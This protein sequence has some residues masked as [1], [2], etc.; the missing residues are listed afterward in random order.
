MVALAI[1]ATLSA[2]ILLTVIRSLQ[3]YY[4]LQTLNELSNNASFAMDDI[5]K[6]LYQSDNEKV[7]INT[8]SDPVTGQARDIMVFPV[9]NS[10][11][12]DGSP[13][14]QGVLAY[15]PF[16]FNNIEQLRKYS[17]TGAL[18]S[19]DFP[20]TVSV[21][22]G[23]IDVY[24]NGGGLIISFDRSGDYEKVLANF[25]STAGPNA[26]RT[27]FDDNNGSISI[28]LFM[29]KPVTGIGGA[30]SR[31]VSLSLNSTVFLRN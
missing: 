19:G 17:Y 4:T 10:A 12:V 20:M 31:Q 16:L 13:I 24:R 9:T 5:T 14:W 29:Q 30:S 26:G 1:V 8:V 6:S 15:Y 11:S 18:V 21:A 22:S 23:T 3:A 2:C 7:F 28:A 25:I 27:F